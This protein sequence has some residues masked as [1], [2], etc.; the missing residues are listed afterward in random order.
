MKYVFTEY[1]LLWASMQENYRVFANCMLY[2]VCVTSVCSQSHST[3]HASAHS[4]A[5]RQSSNVS[6]HR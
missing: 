4:C 6:F 1:E 2:D 5:D 3:P